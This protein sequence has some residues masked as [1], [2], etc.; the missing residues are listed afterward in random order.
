MPADIVNLRLARKRKERAGREA[1]AEAN[2]AR[3][4]RS[5]G[6]KERDRLARETSDRSLDGHRLTPASTPDDEAP[7][8]QKR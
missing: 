4:G 6:E 1:E 3:F 7:S 8:G 2:R 5:R